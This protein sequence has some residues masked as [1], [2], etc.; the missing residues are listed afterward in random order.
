MNP[1]GLALTPNV[2]AAVLILQICAVGGSPPVVWSVAKM[3]VL[4]SPCPRASREFLARA[5]VVGAVCQSRGSG[6]RAGGGETPQLMPIPGSMWRSD[7][8]GKTKQVASAPEPRTMS[9]QQTRLERPC[10]WGCSNDLL[11]NLNP[12]RLSPIVG[13]CDRVRTNS[14]KHRKTLGRVRPS[15]AKFVSKLSK[16]GDRTITRGSADRL[17]PGPVKIGSPRPTLGK[18]VAGDAHK[19]IVNRSPTKLCRNTVRTKVAGDTQHGDTEHRRLGE[20]VLHGSAQSRRR[21]PCSRRA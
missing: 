14:G 18:Q 20:W 12:G 1:C 13:S 10:L 19:E 11:R 5:N 21:I 16:L 4:R 8:L 17:G 2:R 3:L 7:W 6:G 15:S 9:C